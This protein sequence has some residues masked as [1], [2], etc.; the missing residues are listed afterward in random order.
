MALFLLLSLGSGP[1]WA[2]RASSLSQVKTVYVQ[3]FEGGEGAAL[4]HDSLAQRLSRSR[5]Q[6]VSSRDSAD[7]FLKG[8]GHVWIRAYISTSVRT[9]QR[10]RRAVYGGYLSLE[11]VGARGEPLWSLL[12]TPGKLTWNNIVDDLAG[13]AA[14][15]LL[16]DAESAPQNSASASSVQGNPSVNANLTGAG[17]TFPAPLY[18]MW[19]QEFEESH[20]GVHISYAPVG[21]GLGIEKLAAGQLDFA[22]SDVAAE[23]LIRPEDSSRLRAVPTVLGAVVPIYNLPGAITDLHLTGEALADIYLGRVTRWSDPEIRK[24]NRDVNLPDVPISVVH[25][26]DSSG[27][28]WVW[29]DFLATMSPAWSSSVSRGTSLHWPI[30]TGAEHNEGVADLVKNTPNS[31]GYVE[32]T[33]AIQNQLAF[34][35]VRNRAGEY[36]HADLDNVEEAAK[37]ADGPGALPRS[38]IN[39]PGRSAYPIVSFTWLVFPIQARDRATRDSLLDLLRWILVSGQKSCSALGYAP[40]PREITEQQLRILNDPPK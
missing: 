32:L 4:I 37:L 15:K 8:T 40:L 30:G 26:S 10:D 38:L 35:A 16:E 13:H 28:T 21:S 5:F 36:I 18:H 3:D 34:A 17:A 6:V 39:A 14:K 7:A 29:S 9:P 1:A 27:T 20:R 25:R 24:S 23:L 22:G 33:Y 2:Q 12:V 19:F 11:L 31:I